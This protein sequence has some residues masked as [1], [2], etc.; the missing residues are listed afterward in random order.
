MNNGLLPTIQQ[1]QN[2]NTAFSLPSSFYTDPE[3]YN[4]EK[5][6][7]FGKSWYCVGLTHQLPKPGAYFTVDIAECPIVLLRDKQGTLRAFFNICSHRAGPI[8]RGS[9]QANL[10][11][12]LYH[13]WCFDLEGNLKGAPE[14]KEA[15]A[16]DWSAHAL[17][18][19]LVS[20]WGCFIFVNH[21]LHAEPLATY[22]GDMPERFQNYLQDQDLALAH[23]AEYWVDA[24]WKLFVETNMENYHEPTLHPSLAPYY[25][26][27]ETE[28]KGNYTYQWCPEKDVAFLNKT[29]REDEHPDT[30]FPGLSPAEMSATRLVTF[31]PNFDLG[32]SPGSIS[33]VIVDPQAVD[34]TRIELFWL[35]PNTE[36]ALSSDNLS[37]MIV[38]RDQVHR[39]DLQILPDLQ[40]R[41]ASGHYRP[42]RI[43]PTREVGLLLFQNL[44][45]QSLNEAG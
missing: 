26:E 15:E 44:V 9:G 24:N 12:C 20:T 11:T 21:D 39:E 23:R 19:L 2:P 13:A 31:F 6:K 45:I 27:I 32:C 10:L 7:I 33:A 22:L 16:F 29:E 5:Q 30:I 41:H 1:Q 36:A 8:A 40:K 28:A 17:T 42:G 35:V 18:P 38:A 34:R 37:P 3:I 43:C 25:K 4:L 14:M